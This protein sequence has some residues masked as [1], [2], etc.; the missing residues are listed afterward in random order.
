MQAM[1]FTK[2]SPSRLH[3]L[4]AKLTEEQVNA[5]VDMG[6]GGLLHLRFQSLNRVLCMELE[7]SFDLRQYVMFVKGRA[8]PI[9]YHD[10]GMPLGLPD[11]GNFFLSIKP[12]FPFFLLGIYGECIAIWMK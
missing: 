8:I 4:H 1:F 11:K 10:V 12:L 7:K 2:C 6:F 3:G 5:V 9:T